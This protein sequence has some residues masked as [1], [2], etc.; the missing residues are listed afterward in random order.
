MTD[1]EREKKWATDR[2]REEKKSEGLRLV[3][4]KRHKQTFE[5]ATLKKKT[6]GFIE[7]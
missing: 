6:K 1:R 7:R 3:K 4:L 2:E 5:K